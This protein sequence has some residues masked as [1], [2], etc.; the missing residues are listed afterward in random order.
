MNVGVFILLDGYRKRIELFSDE[1]IEITSTVQN[2]A[3]ISKV[4][5]DYSQSFSIPAT[6]SNNK[7]FKHWYE[8]S[9]DNGYNANFRVNAE[10]EIDTILFR[11][12][13]IQLEGATKENGVIKDYKI[14]FYGSL[15]SLADK[16]GEDK[17]SALTEINDIIGF[18]YNATNVVNSVV[19]PNTLPI[20]FPLIT[21]NKVWQY[22]GGGDGDVSNISGNIKFS[23]LFPAVTVNSIF[24]AIQ[25][26]YGVSFVG[27]FLNDKRFT[28]LFLYCKNSENLNYETGISDIHFTNVSGSLWQNFIV[29]IANNKI[30]YTGDYTFYY[31][32]SFYVEIAPDVAS[33]EYEIQ[34]FKNGSLFLKFNDTGSKSFALP[35]QIGEYSFKVKANGSYNFTIHMQA[36][37]SDPTDPQ[38]DAFITTSSNANVNFPISQLMPDMKITEFFSGI[39]KMFNLTAYSE[40]ENIYKIEQIEDWYNNGRIFNITKYCETSEEINKVKSYGELNFKYEKSESLINMAFYDAFQRYYGDL[41]YKLDSDDEDFEIQLPFENLMHQKFSG[42][43]LHVGFCLKNDLKPYQPKPILLYK[44]GNIN[45]NVNFY[46]EGVNRTSYNAFGQD[47]ERV[48]GEFHSL[49]W[50]LENSTL[51]DGVVENSLFNDYYSNYISNIYSI[52]SRIVK[53]NAMANTWLLSTLKLNDRVI[54]RDK[55]YIINSMTTNLTNGQIHFELITDLRTI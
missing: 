26:K 55:R 7:I 24:Q 43:K 47:V 11:R 36:T 38:Y 44:F 48:S 51:L 19:N 14:T 42:T 17:L 10:I 41:N 8:N 29:D 13:R 32:E 45:T 12:G 35:L 6:P 3:D 33:T 22:G 27:N 31:D 18:T 21:S 23:D 15:K 54:I 34:V 1:T 9:L 4:F 37:N 2:I 46:L 40:D 53:I 20:G 5:T 25:Q 30:T 39:L 49:N 52:R 16:L 28:E 50:G